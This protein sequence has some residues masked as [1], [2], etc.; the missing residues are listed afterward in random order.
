MLSDKFLPKV[1]SHGRPS[2]KQ[3]F[4]QCWDKC[5]H[6]YTIDLYSAWCALPASAKKCTLSKMFWAQI[7]VTGCS[8]TL[9]TWHNVI[10]YHTHCDSKCK[11]CMSQ[12]NRSFNA[13]KYQVSE[14]FSKQLNGSWTAATQV[15]TAT[16]AIAQKRFGFCFHFVG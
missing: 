9:I 4:I 15:V 13:L 6:A 3:G 1:L 14:Q 2:T 5:T 8:T 12:M 10:L 7:I 16:C 11:V